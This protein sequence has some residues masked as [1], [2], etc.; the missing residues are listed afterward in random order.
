MADSEDIPIIEELCKDEEVC[1]SLDM[2]VQDKIFMA[3]DI[4]EIEAGV[5]E[6]YIDKYRK[7]HGLPVKEM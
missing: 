3:K 4:G 2:D 1:F 6:K 5:C 7:K